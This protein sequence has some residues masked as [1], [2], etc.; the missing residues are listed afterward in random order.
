[1]QV[2]ELLAVLLEE[3]TQHES[4][5]SLLSP[6][7]LKCAHRIDR[8]ALSDDTALASLFVRLRAV[9]EA[10]DVDQLGQRGES[11]Q[12]G[13]NADSQSTRRKA[14]EAQPP[15]AEPDG[16]APQIQTQN[17]QAPDGHPAAAD[18]GGD[19]SAR[20]EHGSASAPP[21]QCNMSAAAAR[22]RGISTIESN[23]YGWLE[24][25]SQECEALALLFHDPDIPFPVRCIAAR[26][27]LS[28]GLYGYTPHPGLCAAAMAAMILGLPAMHHSAVTEQLLQD[29]R[30]VG[31]CRF[32]GPDVTID[33]HTGLLA[34]PLEPA[35][36][37]VPVPRGLLPGEGQQLVQWTLLRMPATL[38]QADFVHLRSVRSQPGVLKSLSSVTELSLMFWGH[39]KDSDEGF[40]EESS[41]EELPPE[42]GC[43]IPPTGPVSLFVSVRPL[44]RNSLC[45]RPRGARSLATHALAASVIA[46]ACCIH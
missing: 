2:I 39:A 27:A 4:S 40:N 41:G 11:Q 43:D 44:S 3:C 45:R 28:A 13:L 42:K 29:R 23:E 5:R 19:G 12:H 16:K 7:L 8:D 26:A 24:T 31:Q 21:K 33:L 6:A 22:Q 9:W 34:L 14:Q 1:M 46:C 36:T 25:G 37:L 38:S 30:H 20:S 17:T 32:L 15:S 10:P 35:D 18:P